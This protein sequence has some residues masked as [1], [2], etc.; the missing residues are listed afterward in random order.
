MWKTENI[1]NLKKNRKKNKKSHHKNNNLFKPFKRA[2]SVY[3]CALNE[4]SCLDTEASY[5][6][7]MSHHQVKF[8]NVITSESIVKCFKKMRIIN[9]YP[10]AWEGGST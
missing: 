6:S 9:T 8:T 2:N 5:E 4:Q 1:I 3:V 7:N 10:V